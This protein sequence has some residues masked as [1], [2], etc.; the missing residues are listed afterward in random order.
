MV[1]LVGLEP[2]E[3]AW[4]EHAA[5]AVLLQAVNYIRSEKSPLLYLENEVLSPVL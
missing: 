4:F 5:F 3:D 2:T 1:G